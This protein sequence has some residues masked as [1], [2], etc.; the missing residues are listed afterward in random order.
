MMLFIVL[1]FA[2]YGSF[3]VGKQVLDLTFYKAFAE[4]LVG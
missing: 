3:L 2:R 4:V 1:S